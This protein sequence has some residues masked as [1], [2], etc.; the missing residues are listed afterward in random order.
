MEGAEVQMNKRI[1]RAA[2]LEQRIAQCADRVLKVVAGFPV[3]ERELI[4]NE[5]L[6][7]NRDKCM[8]SAH[9]DRQGEDTTDDKLAAESAY[10]I[11]AALARPPT[12]PFPPHEARTK[13]R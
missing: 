8:V 11:T 5:A 2:N 1:R 7:L 13:L 4:L 9:I 6:R 3:D 12:P 10:Q